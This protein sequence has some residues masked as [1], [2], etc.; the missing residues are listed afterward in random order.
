MSQGKVI[1]QGQ[2]LSSV[3][4]WPPTKRSVESTEQFAEVYDKLGPTITGAMVVVELVHDFNLSPDTDTANVAIA[5]WSRH[6]LGEPFT[7]LEDYVAYRHGVLGQL[8]FQ[9]D[10]R[11]QP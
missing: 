8:H 10:V 2:L 7:S 3:A 9:A 1:I 11:R 5:A 6:V 4:E